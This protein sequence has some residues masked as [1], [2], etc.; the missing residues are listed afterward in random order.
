M[1]AFAPA[2][3]LLGRLPAGEPTLR[4]DRYAL[5]AAPVA[6]EALAAGRADGRVVLEVADDR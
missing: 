2:D 1:R 3:G 6:W 4:T 5:A